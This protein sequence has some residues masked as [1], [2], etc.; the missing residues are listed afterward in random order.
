MATYNR[1]IPGSQVKFHHQAHIISLLRL[2]LAL[3]RLQI[4]ARNALTLI[5][6]R[7]RKLESDLESYQPKREVRLQTA[8]RH[9]IT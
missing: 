8:G 1:R 7:K 4:L 2:H 6:Q 5:L 3:E 9:E